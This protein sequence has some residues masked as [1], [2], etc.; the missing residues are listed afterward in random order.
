MIRLLVIQAAHEKQFEYIL[1]VPFYTHS[2][3]MKV[4]VETSPVGID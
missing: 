1:S 2:P 4:N 3:V